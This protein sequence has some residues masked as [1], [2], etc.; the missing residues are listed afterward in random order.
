MRSHTAISAR[1]WIHTAHCLLCPRDSPGVSPALRTSGPL[2]PKRPHRNRER[3]A[4]GPR[5]PSQP[6]D[7]P[8]HVSCFEDAGAF[9]P[10]GTGNTNRGGTAPRFT[11]QPPEPQDHVSLLEDVGASAPQATLSKQRERPPLAPDLPLSHRTHPT[12]S[13]R[14]K[15]TGPL[16][17]KGHD[18]HS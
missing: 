3:T 7:P 18:H 4:I 9:A 11:S 5:F 17:P 8:N 16:H 15:D 13:P 14:Q 6:R 10:Q 12:T 2:H 1:R